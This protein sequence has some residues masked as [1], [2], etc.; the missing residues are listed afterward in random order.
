MPAVH[1]VINCVI[2][3]ELACIALCCLRTRRAAIAG[4]AVAIGVGAVGAVLLLRPDWAV[5]ILPFADAVF[6]ANWFPY[7]V[8]LFAPCA[9]RLATRSRLHRVRVALLCAA[10]FAVSLVEWARLYAPPANTGVAETDADGIC[11]QS[12]A[13]TCAA[14]SVVTVLAQYGIKTTERQAAHLALTKQGRGTRTLGTWRALKSL[15]RG[16]TLT[17]SL[18]RIP[19]KQIIEKKKPAVIVVGL[20]KK[21]RTDA[22]RELAAKHVWTPGVWHEVVYLGPSQRPGFCRIA[23]P[24]LGL[25]EWPTEHLAQLYQGLAFTLDE[26]STRAMDPSGYLIIWI[27]IGGPVGVMMLILWERSPHSQRGRYDRLVASTREHFRGRPELTPAQFAEAFF[28]ENQ[29]M[30][31]A[32]VARILSG[33]AAALEPD[34]IARMQPDDRIIDDLGLGVFDYGEMEDVIKDIEKTFHIAVEEDAQQVSTVRDLVE[35]IER[36]LS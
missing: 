6:Y 7:A 28:P 22:E 4:V 36:K 23:D 14:A 3:L 32:E 20:P 25:E 19:A 24:D 17:V 33:V 9:M 35:Y 18:K 16:T 27:L 8:A 21:M 26:A 34:I 11:R 15:T 5:V 31:A 2:V 12:S 13:D 1:L 29:R 10:L 30:I